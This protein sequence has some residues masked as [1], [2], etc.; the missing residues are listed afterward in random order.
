MIALKPR[1]CA[2]G[3]GMNFYWLRVCVSEGAGLIV[4]DVLLS[5]L[6]ILAPF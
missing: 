5:T 4:S 3:D 1:S 6:T 2:D